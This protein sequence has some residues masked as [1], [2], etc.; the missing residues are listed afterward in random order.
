MPAQDFNVTSI[1]V[2]I[3]AALGLI[4]GKS[5]TGQ[6]VSTTASLFVRPSIAA[7]SVSDRHFHITSGEHFTIRPD[8]TPI[9]CWTNDSSGCPVIVDEAV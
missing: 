1:P 4:A 6:N 7:P 2:D 5:Y 9:W 8:A 3:V